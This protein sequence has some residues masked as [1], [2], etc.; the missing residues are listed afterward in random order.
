MERQRE[1]ETI[2][3]TEISD[4]A[5]EIQQQIREKE[6]TLKQYLS[7]TQ[8]LIQEKNILEKIRQSLLNEKSKLKL[9]VKEFG[10]DLEKEKSELNDKTKELDKI[11]KKI[12]TVGKTLEEKLKSLD[13]SQKK[14]EEITYSFVYLLYLWIFLLFT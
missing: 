9:V 3:N 4:E 14:E 10:V 5:S 6:R 11:E 8:N 12:K 7:Q 2:S 1:N 13:A